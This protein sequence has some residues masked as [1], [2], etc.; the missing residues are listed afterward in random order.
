MRHRRGCGFILCV[1]VLLFSTVLSAS[2]FPLFYSANGTAMLTSTRGAD[3]ILQPDAGGMVA[4]TAL[5]SAQ[6]GIMLN[7]TLLNEAYL[8]GIAA[9]V[10]ALAAMNVSDVSA[11]VAQYASV[12]PVQLSGPPECGPPGGDRLQYVNGSWICVCVSGWAGSDCSVAPLYDFGESLWTLDSCGSSGAVGPTLNACVASYSQQLS[13]YSDSQQLSIKNVSIYSFGDPPNAAILVSSWQRLLLP[14]AGMY[15]IIAAGASAGSYTDRSRGAAVKV[16]VFLPSN[17][18]LY[19]MVGQSGNGGCSGGGGGTFVLL[20]NG[21]V[22]LV[23]GGGGG[24][25]SF[26]GLTSFY[27][28]SDASLNSTSGNPSSDGHLGGV[29]GYGGQSGTSYACGGAG[30]IGD[31]APAPLNAEGAG[32]AAL[33]GGGGHSNLF[34]GYSGFGG[35]GSTF[36]RCGGGGGGGGYSGGG[37]SN[38]QADTS[39]AGGGGGSFCIFGWSNCETTYNVGTGYVTIELVEAYAPPVE[40]A[41]QVG[42]GSSGVPLV[43]SLSALAAQLATQ[44]ATIANLTAQLVALERRIPPNR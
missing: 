36:G 24:T 7:G 11:L 40:S 12:A 22:F 3:V 38:D 39:G 28:G 29:D 27:N 44:Q 9:D 35:G 26:G 17:T 20:G 2:A 4:A 34:T 6:A 42:G 25:S 21:T 23:A 16:N 5:F 43:T 14:Q 15:N 13:I 10:S 31:G 1:V 37:G 19:V 33:R 30:L 18:V 8:A 32:V 41:G